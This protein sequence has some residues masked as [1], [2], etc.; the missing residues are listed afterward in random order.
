MIDVAFARG[1]GVCTGHFIVSTD[2][3]VDVTGGSSAGFDVLSA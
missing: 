2:S 3:L 1:F